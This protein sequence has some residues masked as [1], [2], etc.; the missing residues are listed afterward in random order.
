MGTLIRTARYWYKGDDRLDITAK[1]KDPLGKLLAPPWPLV[2]EYKRGFESE[3]SYTRQYLGL[4]EDRFARQAGEFAKLR[5]RERIVL[6]CFC[7][8]DEFCHRFLA[9]EWLEDKGIGK[10]K[11]EI[12]L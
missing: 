11:G 9:A 8:T 5:Q 4:L 12:K 1:S 7:K 3:N 10:Y 2:L 6:V